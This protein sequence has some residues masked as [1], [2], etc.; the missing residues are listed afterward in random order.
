M[1]RRIPALWLMLVL[2]GSIVA[3]GA[4][5]EKSAEKSKPPKE[6]YY[7][8]YKILVDAMDQVER[9]YVKELDRR[10]IGLIASWSPKQRETT[11]SQALTI[12][13]SQKKLGVRV[14]VNANTCMY[15][16]FNGDDRTAH[17]DEQGKPFWDESFDARGRPHHMGC[18]FA[19]ESRKDPVREQVEFFAEAYKQAGVGID[20]VFVDWEIDGPIEVNRSHQASK[21]CARCRKNIPNIEDFRKFQK[22]LRDIRSHLQRYALTDPIR[23]RSFRTSIPRP[24]S[25]STW[26]RP[27]WAQLVPK[28]LSRLASRLFA[29]RRGNTLCATGLQRGGATRA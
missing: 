5:P 23:S 27:R 2:L 24:A 14:N 17:V 25:R 9:N 15:R 13:R 22:T 21:K 6:D 20:F 26:A 10:G 7:E 12:A 3:A 18:P 8:L 29:S 4:A 11:L 28:A 1:A 19:I 16:F